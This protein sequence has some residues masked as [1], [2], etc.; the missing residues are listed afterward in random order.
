MASAQ[1]R[2]LGKLI[3]S[4]RKRAGLEQVELGR[5]LGISQQSVSRWEAG[6]SRPRARQLAS[7]ARAIGESETVLRDAAGYGAAAEALPETVT[8]S[9]DKPFPV[10]ALTPE[11]F[12]R[13]IEDIVRTLYPDAREVR[14]AG[15]AGHDQAGVDV[16]AISSGGQRYIFQCKRVTRFGPADVH[17]VVRA[18]TTSAERKYLVLSRVASPQTAEAMRAYPDWILWDKN[19]ITRLI[20]EELAPIS[21]R[22]LVDKYFPGQRYALTGQLDTGPWQTPDEFFAPFTGA[23]ATFSH[24][25]GLVGRACEVETIVET[26]CGKANRIV[27]LL[28]AG[29]TGKSRVLKDVISKLK[30]STGREPLLL[31]P[32]EQLSAAALEMLDNGQVTVVVDDAHDRTDLPALFSFAANSARDIRI[33]LASRLYARARLRG[34][35]GQFA[36]GGAI[37]E[38][39]L[40]R[41]DLADTTKLA[42][43]VLTC[44]GGATDFAEPIARATL[45]CP[46]VTVLAAR[47]AVQEKLP[48]AMALDAAAFRDTILGKF[49]KVVTG[50]LAP[51]GE[52]KN[53]TEILKLISLVQPFSIEDAAFRSLATAV[54][55]ITPDSV[56]ATLRT[57]IEGGI[58]FR[59][60]AQYRLMPDLLGDY[61]I[62]Q[63][64]IGVD[65]RLD[66]FADRVFTE[67]V[68]PLLGHVLV[69]LGR[70][71][72]RRSSGN[73]TDSH[74]LAHLWRAL[75]VTGGY[76]DSALEAAASAAFYQPRQA[77]DFVARQWQRGIRQ[78]EL[79]KIVRH[80]A[81]S[82]DHVS[83]ACGL[84]WEMGRNDNREL[85]RFPNHA[86]RALKELCEVQPNKPIAFN[87]EVVSFGL[88][89]ID[90]PDTFDAFH[91]PF[92]FLKGILSGEGH[93]TTGDDRTITFKPFTVNYGAVCDM[94]ERVI[95]R[96]IM[97][98]STPSLRA[99]GQAADFLGDA[100]RYPMGSFGMRVADS[101]IERYTAEFCKTIERLSE[102]V[103][104]ETIDPIVPVA[105][106]HA[107]SWHAHYAGGETAAI[108]R[109]LF[110]ALPKSLEFRLLGA[111][112]DG[113]GQIFLGRMDANTWQS[114]LNAWIEA[115]VKDVS[116]AYPKAAVLGTVIENALARVIEAGL[117]KRGSSRTL[118]HEI[119]R[120]RID[121]ARLVVEDA[122][123]SADS[124][125]SVYLDAALS[126]VLHSDPEEGRRWARH[127]LDTGNVALQ[128]AVGRAFSWR[129]L[130]GGVLAPAD[131]EIFK[132]VLSSSERRV[133]QSG[134]GILSAL[135]QN[136]WRVALDLLRHTNLKLDAGLADE[137]F[138]MFFG[139]RED[140]FSTLE[141]GDVRYLFAELKSLPELNGYWIDTLLSHLSRHF[142]LLT[143]EFFLS[144]VDQ[145]ATS[146]EEFSRIRPINYGPY[147]QVP[148]RF[149]EAQRYS[150]VLDAVWRWMTVRDPSDWRFEHQASALFEGMFLPIDQVVLEFF[151]SKIAI[152]KE[153]DLRWIGSVLARTDS[154][155]VFDHH[156]I[157]VAFLDACDRAGD[158]ARRSGI[159]ALHSSAISGIR[160]GRPGE[161]FDRD[162]EYREASLR[163]MPRLP[164]LSAA[165]ELY[166]MILAHS[167]NSIALAHRDA[168]S[169]DDA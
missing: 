116:V 87:E 107:V 55:G 167:E 48:L 164:R 146:N 39:E 154:K 166:N 35:A 93:V 102:L 152:A 143:C 161:P 147:A 123:K 19:D 157:V 169:F 136:G 29:G 7:L 12:E 121:L 11:S 25:W 70:L 148:L 118:I 71:D 138:M 95:D 64:C 111:L 85:G 22:K 44:F 144:R 59:R 38:V 58:I 119:L 84:L 56:S 28:G 6:L 68:P 99:I 86:M 90:K 32:T 106:A 97:L 5:L 30:A 128:S 94:R 127:L 81:Y 2:D 37:K 8:I 47:I 130:E 73:P 83:E 17:N 23:H 113:F 159:Q 65:D 155:F 132:R 158:S 98:L 51:A 74:L 103:Q 72:W 104:S 54:T 112:S 24:D 63:T 140:I 120:A 76:H 18:S 163:F 9:H 14:P 165:Y 15:K 124:R 49:A 27:L 20:R 151:A 50:E 3:T 108:A 125:L 117:A 137:A 66:S 153:R 31:S 79:V 141:E 101:V 52:Q 129:P 145:A 69:N 67:A 109:E 126:K 135:A 78:D 1:F 150:A 168:E 160:R 131:A 46:L 96:A 26:L 57:L 82:L 88:R 43:E 34:Q 77:L 122:T 162:V 75:N 60:G 21:R 156:D 91:S 61:I 10:D 13:L 149:K 115:L 33:L 53:F 110:A 133:V 80:A 100:I 36:R 4:G 41:L 16:L 134:L 62:E 89:L 40:K 42:A 139:N 92:E 45:D 114:R 105:I 142:P